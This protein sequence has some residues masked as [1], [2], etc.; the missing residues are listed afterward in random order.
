V[1]DWLYVKHPDTGAIHPIPD[2]PGVSD[3]FTRRGWQLTDEPQEETEAE[4]ELESA[5]EEAPPKSSK[6]TSSKAAATEEQ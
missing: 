1:V 4:A 3:S 5:P 2:E 6:K